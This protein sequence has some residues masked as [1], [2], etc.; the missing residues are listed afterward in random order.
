MDYEKRNG[1]KGETG[2]ENEKFERPMNMMK[3]ISGDAK[4]KKNHARDK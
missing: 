3:I 2:E 1:R 4:Q